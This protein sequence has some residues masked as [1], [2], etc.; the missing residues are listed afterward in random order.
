[1]NAKEFLASLSKTNRY[2]A[3]GRSHSFICLIFDGINDETEI[4]VDQQRIVSRRVNEAYQSLRETDD[5]MT[6]KIAMEIAM[7]INTCH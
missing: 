6:C 7:Y 2:S 5:S 4:N 3:D 1:M